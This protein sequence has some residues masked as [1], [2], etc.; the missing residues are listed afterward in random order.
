MNVPMV[1][2]GIVWVLVADGCVTMP[3][4]VRLL[5]RHARVVDVPVVFVMD[6]AVLML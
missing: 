6:V 3:M 2:V 5:A 1:Q 4:G